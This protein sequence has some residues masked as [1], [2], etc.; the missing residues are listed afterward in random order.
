MPE[1]FELAAAAVAGAVLGALF[2]GALW[3]TVKRGLTTRRPAT[4]FSSSVVVRMGVT[5]GGFWL[6][7]AGQWQRLVACV[8]GFTAV[9]LLA[10]WLTRTPAA[11]DGAPCV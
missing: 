4:L 10:A 7:S 9:R 2:F 8:L 5:L 3:W 6:V 1:P 11:P